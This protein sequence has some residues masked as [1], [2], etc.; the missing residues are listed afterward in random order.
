ML[1]F[2]WLLLCLLILVFVSCYVLF[3]FTCLLVCMFAFVF[4]FDFVALLCF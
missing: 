2:D 3:A 1:V 4:G